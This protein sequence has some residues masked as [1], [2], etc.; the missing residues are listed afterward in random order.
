LP[1]P[2]VLV[3]D[4]SYPTPEIALPIDENFRHII[5]SIRQVDAPPGHTAIQLLPST[6]LT[7]LKR[8]LR[9]LRSAWLQ[10]AGGRCIVLNPAPARREQVLVHC[11]YALLLSRD[12][13]LFDGLRLRPIEACIGLLFKACAFTIVKVAMGPW[14]R[15]LKAVLFRI[16][17]CRLPRHSTRENSL[18]GIYTTERT[19]SIPPDSIAGEADKGSIYGDRTN[20]WYLPAFSGRRRRYSVQTNRYRMRDVSLHVE[21][22]PGGSM[23]FVFQ[24]GRMLDYPY[25]LGRMQS[26]LSYLVST[27]TQVKHLERGVN[28]LAYTTGYYHWLVEGIPRILDVIDDGVDFDQYPLIL[29]QLAPFQSQMLEILGIAPERQVV[30]LRPGEW[31][32]VGECIF[33][34]IAFAFQAP[35]MEDP[36][37]QP[38]RALMLRVRHRL[39]SRL[40]PSTLEIHEP[41]RRVY[42]SR[43]KAARRKLTPEAEIAV[44]SVLQDE[45][46]SILNLEDLSWPEQVRLISGAEFVVGL[47]GAGLANIL[48]GNA[49]AFLE[50]HNPLETRP[51]F[52]FMARELDIPY[53]YL[54]GSLQGRSADFDNIAIDSRRV[55]EIVHRMDGR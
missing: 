50:F 10:E 39:Q 26:S 17:N 51:H 14:K 1:S 28:L 12:V 6:S 35:D 3:F 5:V 53:A 27:R 43:A 54:I 22:T 31:C 49:K 34:T 52:A 33:P 8:N 32:H 41:P 46:F 11:A 16:R 47:H 38:D 29:P 30:V 19:F 4:S 18:F 7:G 44:G 36:S 21:E 40:V 15:R 45:G 2:A 9:S 55:R 20:G 23:S 13:S 42:V 37:G 25:L 48:F 24:K